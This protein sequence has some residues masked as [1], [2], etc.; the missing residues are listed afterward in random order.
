M[1]S[2]NII[3][4]DFLSINQLVDD[5]FNKAKMNA[6]NCCFTLVFYLKYFYIFPEVFS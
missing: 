3:S 2:R 5:L 4:D 6:P 1:S